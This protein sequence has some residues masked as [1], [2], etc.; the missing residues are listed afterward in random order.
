MG[1]EPVVVEQIFQPGLVDSSEQLDGTV[2]DGSEQVVVDPAKQGDRF[3]VPAPP[4][5]VS[6]LL[7]GLQTFG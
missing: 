3:V 6:Q 5:V 2:L 1:Q 4:K 7:K